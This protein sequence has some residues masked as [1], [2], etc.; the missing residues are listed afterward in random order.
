MKTTNAKDGWTRKR[1]V[2]GAVG[3]LAL[4]TALAGSDSQVDGE[5]RAIATQLGQMGEHL[6]GIKGIIPCIT[7]PPDVTC[8]G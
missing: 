2:A 4:G 5:L 7:D 6:E 3:L 8:S 1:F